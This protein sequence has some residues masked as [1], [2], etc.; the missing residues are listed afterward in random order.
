MKI[1]LN[2]GQS[3]Q[4]Q[5]K[6]EQNKN[7]ERDILA[8]QQGDWNAKNRLV[9]Q[10]TP[11]LTSLAEKRS[12]DIAKINQLIEAG[13]QGLFTAAKKYKTSVGPGGFQIFALDFIEDSMNGV[14]LQGVSGSSGGFFARLF[15]RK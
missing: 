13:K 14:R 11:L 15:G 1:S 5:S 2:M 7:L 10:F 6:D 12:A 4:A 3:N 8:A 9:K